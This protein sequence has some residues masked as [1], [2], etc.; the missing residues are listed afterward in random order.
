MSD[1]TSAAAAQKVLTI[2]T[3][4]HVPGLWLCRKTTTP[5]P[6]SSSAQDALPSGIPGASALHLRHKSARQ[7][8]SWHQE[9]PAL[10]SSQQDAPSAHDPLRRAEAPERH[11]KGSRLAHVP[12]LHAAKDASTLSPAAEHEAGVLCIALVLPGGVFR[13]DRRT[14][15][16]GPA[17]QRRPRCRRRRTATQT[18]TSRRPGRPF[19]RSSLSS[20][21]I[22]L[23]RPRPFQPRRARARVARQ[24]T[25]VYGL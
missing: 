3:C 5:L 13:S 22:P 10:L 23:R 19:P 25:Q 6:P 7:C 1:N 17:R 24:A 4:A 2:I 15:V 14:K 12:L 18:R 9:Q 8:T 16:A 21:P 20:T 11:G